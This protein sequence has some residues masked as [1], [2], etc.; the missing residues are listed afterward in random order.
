[1]PIHL[2]DIRAFLNRP[3]IEGPQ[4]L[5]GYIPCRM[6]TGGSANYRGP[7]SGPPGDFEAMGV[8]GVTIATGVDL[9]QT[10]ADT[11]QR[12]GLCS[13]IADM[14]RPYFGLRR[15][16]A[17]RKLHDL[18]L[19]VSPDTAHELDR[20]THGIHA[21]RISARYDGAHPATPFAGLPP[22]AQAAIFSLLYQRGT[23]VTG[24]CPNTWAALVAGDWRDAAARLCNASLW[25]GYQGRRA[26]EGRLLKEIV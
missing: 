14:L 2:A 13:G 1:M 19:R 15:D 17:I 16:A 6:K 7:S 18:P 10:D 24:K 4:Q 11:L 23:G 5:D 25:E 9:G 21:G 20:V 8:S 26:L 22:Q 3:G 12:G